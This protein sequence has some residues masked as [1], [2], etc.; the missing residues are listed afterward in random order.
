MRGVMFIVVDLLAQTVLLAID[1]SLFVVCQIAAV[2]LSVCTNLFVEL[3][4]LA[5]EVRSLA[6]REAAALHA[7]CNTVLL[8]LF[9]IVNAIVSVNRARGRQHP[10]R[11][12]HRQ[13]VSVHCSISS[14]CVN[15]TGA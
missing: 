10:A 13:E 6:G 9:P 3:R 4:L 7:L 1:L 5:F 11:G 15:A 2:G 12:H 8:I 14:A